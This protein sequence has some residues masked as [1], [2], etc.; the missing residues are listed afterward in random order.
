MI[1]LGADHG[2][3]LLKYEIKQ[4]LDG[5]GVKYEDLTPKHDS[6]DDYPLVAEMVAK[7]VLEH[8]ATGILVCGTG[9]GISIA[10]NRF[11]GIRAAVPY[12]E[13]TA[14]LAREHNEA[15]IL[16][17]G[18]RTMDWDHTLK[19]ITAWLVQA[20][21]QEGRHQRRVHQLDQIS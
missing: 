9:I 4:H 7:H 14:A 3:F 1:Y 5:M 19:Y 13:K 17:L 20:V 18:E 16:C 8:E 2:G 10:A 12:S 15:N 11:K 21:S 6:E